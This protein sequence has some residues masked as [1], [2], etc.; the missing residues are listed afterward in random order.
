MYQSHKVKLKVKK[1]KKK[2]RCWGIRLE[3]MMLFFKKKEEYTRLV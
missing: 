2:K 1:K 3:R